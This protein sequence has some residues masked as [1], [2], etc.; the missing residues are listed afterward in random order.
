M[1]MNKKH[2][3]IMLACC[4]IPL[5][6]LAAI[7][8]FGVPANGVIYFGLIVLCPALHL[9][10]MRGMIGHNHGGHDEPGHSAEHGQAGCQAE[11]AS[12]PVKRAAAADGEPTGR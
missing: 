1:E 10:M 12:T 9:L 5:V 8:I 4:L 11:A 7:W 3:L 6:G 2:L